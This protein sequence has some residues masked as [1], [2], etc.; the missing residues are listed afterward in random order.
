MSNKETANSEQ[1]P[2]TTTEEKPVI[3]KPDADLISYVEKG[4]K[5]TKKTEKAKR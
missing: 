1:E 3:I 5:P 4:Q 2:S